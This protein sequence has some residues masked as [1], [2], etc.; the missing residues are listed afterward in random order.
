MQHWTDPL[1]QLTKA[2]DD[3]EATKAFVKVLSFVPESKD[4]LRGH[5]TIKFFDC[6]VLKGVRLMD[7]SKG[8]WLAMPCRRTKAGDFEDLAFMSTPEMREMVLDLVK[9]AYE[10]TAKAVR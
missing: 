2:T 1:K 4:S 8:L 6:L 7:G 10:Q 3:A 9:E 5:A